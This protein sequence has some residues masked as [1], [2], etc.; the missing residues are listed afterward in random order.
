MPQIIYTMKNLRKVT[1]Q[2]KEI[3]KGIDLD[4]TEDALDW[5]ARLGYDPI[6]GA[7]PL[8]RVI[9]KHIVNPLAERMLAGEFVEGDTVSVTSNHGG[10]FTFTK[11]GL[12]ARPR[13]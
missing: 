13:K 4:V 8:K 6:Y 1:P 3:L 2:G 5:L 11:T 7:R 10:E 12:P 9:Q